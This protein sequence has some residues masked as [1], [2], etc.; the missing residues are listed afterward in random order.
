MNAA[1]WKCLQRGGLDPPLFISP[2]MQKKPSSTSA[3]TRRDALKLAGTTLAAGLIAPGTFGAAR[4]TK[5]VIVAGAGIGGLCCAYELMQLGHD[6]TVLGASSRTGG[7]IRTGFGFAA[8]RDADTGS[9][10]CTDC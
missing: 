3:V 2:T 5:K 6:G 8:G 7:H 1:T 4:R 10:Q 9:G